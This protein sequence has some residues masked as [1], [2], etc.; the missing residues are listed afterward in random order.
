MVYYTCLLADVAIIVKTLLCS[1]R[2]L[3]LLLLL[4]MFIEI[5][6]KIDVC[7]F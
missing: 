7:A 1:I 2:I 6:G 5:Y 3:L 4:Y